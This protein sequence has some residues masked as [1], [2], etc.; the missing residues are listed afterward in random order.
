VAG[1]Y[2]ESIELIKKG[3]EDPSGN[4]II[5]I[6]VK[7]NEFAIYEVEDSDINNRLKVLID[8]HTPDKE[9]DL[10]K[11]FNKV[12]QNYIKAKGL[13][14][15]SS[16]F[17]MMKNRI[18]HLLSTIFTTEDPNYDGNDEFEKL[19]IEIKTEYSKSV[20]HRLFYL[21]PS[22]IISV[23]FGFYMYSKYPDWYKNKIELWELLCVVS[24]ALIGGTMSIIFRIGKNNF[25]EHLNVWYYFFIGIERITLS[26]F[27]AAIAFAGVKSGI[28]FGNIDN[29]GYWTILT[30]S[31][32]AGFSEAL[33]PGLLTKVSNG[34]EEV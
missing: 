26:I 20:K 23:F 32:V 14:Y 13:L 17:G 34:K 22:I 19:I 10:T 11:R 21:L 31:I 12:K 1:D 28:L 25:E 24:G 27:A 3:E 4:K 16:N 2:T 18:A 6:F 33:I 8:G 30:I 29:K 5:N 9:D 7:Y 15:R